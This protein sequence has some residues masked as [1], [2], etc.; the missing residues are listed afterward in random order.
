MD[1]LQ[2]ILIRFS[3][4][5]S[6]SKSK[7]FRK[8]KLTMPN[9]L[10]KM[11]VFV[12]SSST[13]GSSRFRQARMRFLPRKMWRLRRALNAHWRAITVS[14]LTLTT[15]YFVLTIR[16]KAINSTRRN[17]GDIPGFRKYKHMVYQC[18]ICI[19]KHCMCTDPPVP[20]F[21]TCYI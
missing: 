16:K 18:L 17:Y 5:P 10:H 9:S 13:S 8:D 12:S 2:Y 11:P 1:P 6:G 19:I 3:F 20:L 7:N 14:V 4:I 21:R 15:L